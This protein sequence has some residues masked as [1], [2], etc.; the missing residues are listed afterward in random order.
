M[1]EKSKPR[2]LN[3]EENR[4]QRR[5][6]LIE[7]AERVIATQDLW[8]TTVE[9]ICDEAGVSHGLL[10]HYF[11]SKD[12]LLLL[13]CERVF[14]EDLA[15]KNEIAADIT[16]SAVNR[17]YEISASNFKSPVY[18]AERVAVWQAFLNASRSARLFRDAIQRGAT[19]YRT[20]FQ[21]SFNEAA[22]ELGIKID[23]KRAALGLIAM[24][25]GFWTGLSTNKDNI[26]PEIAIKIS[27]SYIDACLGLALSKKPKNTSPQEGHAGV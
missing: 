22:K 17:L 27:H 23:S 9:R 12:D 20:V 7:A 18:N 3:R 1:V 19:E 16:L 15:R 25:D 11:N 26:T 6:S 2:R 21:N 10:G 14:K 5:D 13:V 8:G 24:V 4:K